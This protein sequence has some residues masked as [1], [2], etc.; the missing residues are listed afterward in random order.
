MDADHVRLGR[1]ADKLAAARVKPLPPKAFGVEAHGF[2]LDPPLPE[3]A[4]AEFE[5]RHE[6]TL[7]AGYRLFITE[8]GAGGA[9]PG[10]RMSRLGTSCCT[11]RRSGH[12]AKPS[13]Y[14]PGPRYTGDW[15]QR[16]EDPP[17]PDRGFLLGTLEVAD[18]GC[19]LSTKLIVTG[20]ARGRLFNLDSD[21]WIGP[22]VVEDADFLSWYERWL[23]E[24]VAGYDV[25]FFGERLPLDEPELIAVLAEDPSPERRAQAGESLL[26]LPAISD[27]TRDA[28]VGAMTSDPDP[29]VRAQCWGL[30]GP[31]RPN[32]TRE[33]E[34]PDAIADEIAHYARSRTPPDL[35]ALSSLRKLS[36]TDVLPELGARHDLERRRK[37]AYQLSEPWNFWQKELPQDLLGEVADGLLSDADPILRKHGVGV[38][39][40]FDLTHFHPRLREMQETE[41]DPWVQHKLTWC[42][43]QQRTRIRD[44]FTAPVQQGNH[45]EPP[46]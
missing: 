46:F 25:G 14:L 23:D 36:Y 30:L 26:M 29:T 7:P 4:V 22:Y 27:R 15:E 3:A 44:D 9:G 43:D 39:D 19:S 24:A 42:L 21:G 10:Y 13:P 38:V 17:G 41:T 1:I 2:K 6:V 20:P 32:R 28:L 16:Y 35:G 31:G 12:L 5:E 40:W 33:L 18:H 45:D 11:Y 37:A 8:L 34:N